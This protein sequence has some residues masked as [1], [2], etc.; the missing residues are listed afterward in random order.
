MLGRRSLIASEEGIQKAEQALKRHNLTKTAIAKEL[1]VAS[2]TTVSKFFNSKPVDRLLFQEICRALDLDWQEIAALSIEDPSD[3]PQ[4]NKDEPSPGAVEQIIEEAFAQATPSTVQLATVMGHASRT[5]KAL[6][7]YILPPIRRESFLERCL[8]QIRGGV[9]GK[10]RVVPILGAAGYGKSTLLGTLY[11]ALIAE[12]I[13][14]WIALVRCDDLVEESDRFPEE[15]GAKVSDTR[16]SIVEV[17]HQLTAHHGRGILL[18]DTLDIVLTKPLVPVFRGMLAQLL[19]SG[20]TVAFTC[21]DNDY[22]DF[23]EPYHQSFAGFREAVYD[24]CKITPFQPEEVAEA[25]GRFAALKPDYPTIES[26]TAF[27]DRILALST[28][29]VSLTEIVTHPLLLALL[30]ELF[31][32][33]QVVPEDLT[34]SQLYDIYW[35]WKI[36]KV[37]HQHQSPRIG[38]T[39]EK[40]CLFL[41]ETLYQNSGERLRDFL[42]ETQFDLSGSA[43]FEAY[44]A[45]RSEGVLKELGNYRIG[46][47]H[48]TFLE[49]AIARWLNATASGELTQAQIRRQLQSNTQTTPHYLWPIFRQYLTLVTLADFEQICHELDWQQLLPFRAI[50]FAAVSRIEPDASGI[51]RPMLEIALARDYAFMETLLVAA[52]SAPIRHRQTAWEIVLYSLS[53]VPKELINKT[54]EIAADWIVQSHAEFQR[55]QDTIA[56]LNA[57]PLVASRL[58]HTLW[59]KLLGDYCRKIR[60]QG[61]AINL[62]VLA[63][64][65]QQYA[66]FG[67]NVRAMVIELYLSPEVPQE[68]Q[69]EFLEEIIEL[70]PANNSFVEHQNAVALLGSILPDLLSNG[71]SRFGQSWLEVLAVPLQPEWM[72]V[73]AA[74]VGRQAAQDA[75]LLGAI[76]SLLFDECSSA[77][78]KSLNRSSAI[79]LQ[80]A[81]QHGGATVVASALVNRD[82]SNLADNRISTLA[83]LLRALAK[84]GEES[85]ELEESWTVQLTE[86]IH[87]LIETYPVELIG[88]LGTFAVWSSQVR[89]QLATILEQA[90]QSLAPKQ[91]NLILKK[92]SYIPPEIAPYLQQNRQSKEART[93]LLKLHWQQAK[94]GTTEAIQEIVKACADVSQDIA[95]EASGMV[96]EL[97]QNQQAVPL[98]SL[99]PLL[100]NSRVIRVR[101]NCMQAILEQ[102]NTQKVTPAQIIQVFQA[103]AQ[104]TTPEVLQLAYK[105]TTAAI[106]KHPSGTRRLEL[107]IAEAIFSLTQTVIPHA[108]QPTIDRIA[109][110]AMIAFNQMVI[111]E[112]RRLIP[113]LIDCTRLL[114]RSVDISGKI[115]KLVVTSLL[116]DL[117]K[118]DPDLFSRMIREDWG[119]NDKILPVANQQA[120]V[121]AIA[122]NQGKMS[123]LLDQLLEDPQVAEETKTRILRD[124]NL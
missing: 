82:I 13:G 47:F 108:P 85:P 63:L 86:W 88:V 109:H 61:K 41:A 119:R 16:L 33:A 121:V 36:S 73:C 14:G 70:P 53:R 15:L 57:S 51:L 71:K 113:Q 69:V 99:L 11:D 115:D 32:E 89:T 29:S 40:L 56:A 7:P 48:Q 5:R 76:V 6:D 18:L 72:A 55:F 37:R 75:E 84:A 60:T 116:N 38:K 91:T 25:A 68:V 103:I 93:A 87:P 67:S 1:A 44:T 96:L 106:W 112:D 95:K 114:F 120:L 28:D 9:E 80:E 39:Q 43:D 17:A 23:F 90:V 117:G 101:Q 94:L 31:A 62:Q 3:S 8:T 66:A 124:R 54:L 65:Q 98:E 45:L 42:Y 22:A 34:V 105:L 30:C 118:F 19:E 100:A 4:E 59:G 107:P 97:V 20:T 12:G 2:W 35:N 10:Q 102:V 50:A 111:L 64:L 79:A 74:A 122:N 78:S 26:Q 21:R 49:Y 27:A 52:N 110:I 83:M 123:P 104:E 46:F 24:G 77:D 92:L 81:I 58:G